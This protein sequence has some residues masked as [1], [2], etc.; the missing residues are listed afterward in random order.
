MLFLAAFDILLCYITGQEDI[1]V[2][3]DSSGRNCLATEGVI[4]F[5]I[6]QL[7]IRTSLQ[8]NPTVREILERV[9]NVALAAY[10]HG[11]TPFSSIVE[12]IAGNRETSR[13]PLFQVKLVLQN[14]P[15]RSKPLV[16]ATPVNIELGVSKYNLTIVILNASRGITGG[17]EYKTDLFHRKSIQRWAKLYEVILKLMVSN[18]T[19]R[20]GEIKAAIDQ[21]NR[22]CLVAEEEERRDAR[23]GR[24]KVMHPAAVAVNS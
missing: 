19:M 2:G 21:F 18:P 4:G 13:S 9:R 17:I 12:A 11:G 15:E 14:F 22:A 23:R 7:V 6:N 1:A 3:T 5:F 16:M 24:F 10:E 8:G 20:L